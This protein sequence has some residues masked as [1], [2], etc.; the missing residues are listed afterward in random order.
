[1]Q[2]LPAPGVTPTA[3]PVPRRAR[4]R[5]ASPPEVLRASHGR[6]RP[7]ASGT[8]SGSSG[9]TSTSRTRASSNA[10]NGLPPDSSWMRSSVW[11]A[12][13]LPSRSCSSRWSAPT[14]SGP[15]GTHSTRSASSACSNAGGSTPATSRR[16]SSTQNRT[17]SESSQRKRQR[18]RRGRVEPLNVVDGKQN[19]LS[20]TEHMEHVAY[21]HADRAVIDRIV[22][23]ASWRRSAI[24]SARRLGVEIKGATSARTPRRGRRA[25]RERARCS[26]SAGRDTGRGAR[27]SARAR[28][29]RATASTCRSRPRPPARARQPHPPPGRRRPRPRR[30]LLPADDLERHG[31]REIVTGDAHQRNLAR[32]PRARHTRGH[33]TCLRVIT[34]PSRV[35]QR[36]PSSHRDGLCRGNPRS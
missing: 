9:S 10:K 3:S 16:A 26:A 7:S 34:A 19:R 17:R 12:N 36:K 29:P 27:A 5:R 24:S 22:W 2:H 35:P 14:L 1:M 4:A 25:P 33:P 6:A 21:R 31:P 23:S 18:A 32:R 11:R 20:L 30:G 15:T 13:D 28:R 8:G